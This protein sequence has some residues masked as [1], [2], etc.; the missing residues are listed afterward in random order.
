ITIPRGKDGFGFTICCDSPVR[1]QAVD[2]GGPAERAGLQQ[3]DTVLQLNERPVEHWKCVE[4]AHEIRSCPSEI[5]LL[6]WRMVPQIKPGPDGGV[7]RRASCKSTHDLQ[8]PPNKR[9]KNCTH[10][11][12]A[13]P[14]QRHSCHLVC[15]SSDGLLLGGW[16]RYTEV[17]K[18]GGQHTLP[19]L[20][21]ATA[22]TDPNYIILAPLNPGSQ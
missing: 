12:Q 11:A 13:R 6:V 3:L 10:G 5:I 22:P 15:D 18:R 7:L 1:V 17:A 16:E 9:E 8:S 19:A 21:R 4:L 20:S 14:E 2:S